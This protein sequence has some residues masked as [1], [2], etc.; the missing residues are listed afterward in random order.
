M[1]IFAEYYYDDQIK[2]YI[3][4]QVAFMGDRF[5]AVFVQIV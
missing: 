2:K 1:Y 3:G 5:L 4:I